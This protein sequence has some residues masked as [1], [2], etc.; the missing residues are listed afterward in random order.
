MA[1]RTQEQSEAAI[2]R[3]RMQREARRR[4]RADATRRRHAASARKRLTRAPE[5]PQETA[6]KERWLDW[7]IIAM[8]EHCRVEVATDAHHALREQV[9]RRFAR[10]HG[11]DFTVARWDRRLRILLC[12]SCHESHTNRSRRL[13]WTVLRAE[14]IEAAEDLGLLPQLEREYGSAA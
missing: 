10:D 14:T 7:P 8:C 11:Y 4:D 13:P 3:A 12:R 9:L 5:S 6:A 2:H 1:L